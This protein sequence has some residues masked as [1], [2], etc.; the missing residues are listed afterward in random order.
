MTLEFSNFLFFLFNYIIMPH[1]Q[2]VDSIVLKT[3]LSHC[4]YYIIFKNN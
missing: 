3:R 2:N 1:N 4:L